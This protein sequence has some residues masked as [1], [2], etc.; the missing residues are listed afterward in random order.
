MRRGPQPAPRPTVR[1]G[2]MP[3]PHGVIL[4]VV[5][6][7][8]LYVV[9][10][11][12]IMYLIGQFGG[13]RAAAAEF[14]AVPRGRIVARGTF[15]SLR[16]GDWAAYNNAVIWAADEDYL[17]L[18][19]IPGINFGTHAPLSIPWSAMEF[20]KVRP[21]WVESRLTPTGV[22]FTLPRRMVEHELRVRDL[23]PAESAP[24]AG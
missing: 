13:W 21:R 22:S 8:A 10:T 12:G 14:P 18:R 19:L 5:L 24:T 7:V 16:F 4:L 17:H 3:Q 1:S 15:G 20:T 9:T 23:L 6:V 11:G 2:A